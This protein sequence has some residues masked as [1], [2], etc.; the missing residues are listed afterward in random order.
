M[1]EI[2]C[3]VCNWYKLCRKETDMF[4]IMNIL[5]FFSF[6]P[7]FPLVMIAKPCPQYDNTTLGRGPDFSLIY[8]DIKKKKD[9]DGNISFVIIIDTA[10]CYSLF[11][12]FSSTVV[13]SFFIM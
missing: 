5:F 10:F 3:E 12:Y 1:N 11:V 2:N 8:P 9:F 7:A 4:S 13:L 6:L